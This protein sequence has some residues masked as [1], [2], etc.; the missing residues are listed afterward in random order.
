MEKLL[1]SNQIY[2]IRSCH[3]PQFFLKLCYN[4][5]Y[6]YHAAKKAG[7]KSVGGQVLLGVEYKS[8]WTITRSSDYL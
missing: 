8:Y 3:L 7:T 4:F 6:F 1:F 5:I 2:R